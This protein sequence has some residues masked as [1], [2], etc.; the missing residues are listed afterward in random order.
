MVPLKPTSVRLDELV[1]ECLDRAQ[2]GVGARDVSIVRQVG[3]GVPPRDL[4][5]ALLQEAVDLI[6]AEALRQ[7]GE[8]RK[9]R[10]MVRGN[11]NALM[12][13]VKVFGPG[14]RDDDRE[15]LF[16]SGALARARSI[17]AAH[18]G[19][20][21]A[22]GRQGRGITYYLTVPMRREPS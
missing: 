5:R 18:G 12:L 19:T 13:S 9:L 14:L 2:A 4:D 3:P 15:A 21:W 22:N 8:Q 7:V 11:S 20:A 17:A 16:R 10:V 1:T 6:L